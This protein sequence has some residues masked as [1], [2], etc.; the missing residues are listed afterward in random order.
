MAF[1]ENQVILIRQGYL[2]VSGL[3]L[4]LI[5]P[6]SILFYSPLSVFDL[7]SSIRSAKPQKPKLEAYSDFP[8][9]IPPLAYSSYPPFPVKMQSP[10]KNGPPEI[11]EMG[12]PLEQ[13][14]SSHISNQSTVGGHNASSSPPPP[15]SPPSSPHHH[16]HHSHA[17][18]ADHHHHPRKKRSTL[19]RDTSLG[20]ADGLTVPFALTAGLASLGSSRLV[21]LGGLAELFSGA[22]SMGLGAYLAAVTEQKQYEV[23]E[24]RARMEVLALGTA[25]ATA[26]GETGEA[27]AGV[28]GEVGVEGGDVEGRDVEAGVR[29]EEQRQRE[30]EVRVEEKTYRVL[31]G[32][33]ISRGAGRG[34]VEELRRRP[35]EWVN[36]CEIMF[37]W[38]R[39]PLWR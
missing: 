35:E 12:H 4:D 34:V 7:L 38:W 9:N 14:S 19:L 18:P 27:A 10:T 17:H 30:R 25:A 5:T 36:V 16:N 11:I 13:H 24:E 20:L 31:A 3:L 23:A 21:I 32:Y 29:G 6:G 33:G 26:V 8:N 37:L 2:M 15:P 22:I 39:Y 1:A 28:G